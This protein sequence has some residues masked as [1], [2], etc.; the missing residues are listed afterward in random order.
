MKNNTEE[1]DKLIKETLSQEEAKFYDELEQQTIFEMI[2]G[3]FQGKNK[4]IMF[5]M[6]FMTLVFFGLFVYCTVQFFNTTATN[7]LI[8]WGVGGLVFLFGVSMLKIFAWMQMDKNA[9]LRELKRL[10]LLIT[11]ASSK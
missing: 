6:N 11:Y 2:G 10:E 3:L 5:L 7:E 4:W 9:L 1:I 8:K